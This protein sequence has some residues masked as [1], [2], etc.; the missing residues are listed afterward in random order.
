MKISYDI[1]SNQTILNRLIEIVQEINTLD[2]KYI[3]EMDAIQSVYQSPSGQLFFKKVTEEYSL[4]LEKYSA[5]CQALEAFAS[6]HQIHME[7]Q[8]HIND[9]ISKMVR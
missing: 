8:N 9:E 6:V 2:Q 3:S 4:F 1:D 5:F 7:T